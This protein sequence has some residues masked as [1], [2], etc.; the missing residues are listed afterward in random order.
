VNT[1]PT[2]SA[3]NA[4]ICSG[5]STVITA[6]G[7]T[8]FTWN[9]GGLTG[10][11]QTLSP[12]STQI[13]SITGSNGL[14]SATTNNTV[15]VNATPT[16]SV[17]NAL[18]CSGSSTTLTA[19]GAT[20]YTW[21][22]GSLTGSTQILNPPSTTVYSVTGANGSC[23]SGITATVTVIGNP[24]ITA[25]NASICAGNSTV[26][27]AIG[28]SSFTWNPG[29]L[30]GATQTLSPLTTQVY[31]ITGM[32]G[33]C[34]SSITRT[35]TVNITPT[36]SV[37]SATICSGNS[38][39]LTVTGASGYTWNPGGLIGG[40]QTLSP[41]STQV[42]TVTGA[43]GNCVSNITSTI[44]VNTSPTVSV[45]GATICTGNS[46]V[47]TASGATSYTWNPGSLS[48]A[49]QTLN[50]A[51]N[52]V[53]TVT[54][55]NGLCSSIATSTVIVNPTPT[56]SASNASLCSGASTVITANGATSYTWNPGALSGATQ[57]LNPG[58]TTVYTITGSNGLCNGTGSSTI[59]VT[60]TPT[61]SVNS[62]TICTGITTTL[63]VS[64]ASAY[65]WSPGGMT[66]PSQTFAP[67]STTVYTING[68][69]GNC[70]ASVNAT[71]TISNSL[72]IGLA[73]SQNTICR[74]QQVTITATG[75]NNY[76]FNPGGTTVNPAT[77]GPLI[78]TN[79]TVNGTSAGCSGTS[80]ITVE[81]FDCTGIDEQ[82]S[83]GIFLYP[84]PTMGNFNIG[85]GKLFSGEITV[86]NDIGQLIIE[87]TVYQKE[88][89]QLDLE[90]YAKGI[91]FVRISS[92]G[93]QP[94]IIKL[95]KI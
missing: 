90:T 50:P 69:N 35:I 22:P 40:S 19:S 41:L 48:G 71:I 59:S 4:T 56:I 55:S 9:P 18:I 43:N 23:T 81:V 44:T 63:T 65:T 88:T 47:L 79:Y 80:T 21:N 20:T 61:L 10:A 45:P 28:A 54:G 2:L 73:A 51:G 70:T 32:N 12:G 78:S 53:Y 84:N 76:T 75:A 82:S 58:T 85:F 13:Y 42:Y 68:A 7:A 62:A 92:E 31:T 46:T 29:A 17:P 3:A 93:H 11:T 37:N 64:G 95:I 94:V 83:A 86:Y 74:G 38:T 39:V 67:V 33:S 34:S 52:T 27:T 16:V 24:T 15:T 14:C 89:E 25:P 57:T 66:N 60:A 91:Y 5:N 87:K 26:L 1:T 72:A 77:F 30:I 8:S 36:L 49:T 6:G